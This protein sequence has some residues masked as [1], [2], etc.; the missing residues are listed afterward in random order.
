MVEGMGVGLGGGGWADQLLNIV[1]R[2]CALRKRDSEQVGLYMVEVVKGM[3]AG[4]VGRGG[5]GWGRPSGQNN[6]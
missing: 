1:A 4:G 3:G 5:E 6:F 2:Q